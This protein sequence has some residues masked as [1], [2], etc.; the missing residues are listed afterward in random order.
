MMIP[1]I[2]MVERAYNALLTAVEHMHPWSDGLSDAVASLK[3]MHEL[4]TF[5]GV[6]VKQYDPSIHEY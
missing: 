6:V 1:N 4:L 2:P 3:E 5:H